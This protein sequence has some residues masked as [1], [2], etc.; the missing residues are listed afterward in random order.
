V[1]LK[2]KGEHLLMIK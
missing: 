2:V 1:L